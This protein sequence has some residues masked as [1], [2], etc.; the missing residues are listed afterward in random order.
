MEYLDVTDELGQPTGETVERSRAHREGIRHRT[1]HVWLLRRKDSRVQILLQKRSACKASYPGCFDI[2]SA[3]HIPAGCGWE[4][5]AL[6]ELREELGVILPAEA[7]IP[8]GVRTVCADT[9]FR[10]V[11]FHDR[12]VSRVYAA[13]TQLEEADFTLQ[14]EEVESV[15]WMDFDACEDAVLQNT[16]PHCIFPGELTILRSALGIPRK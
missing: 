13:W 4:E 11:P 14:Q 10:G 12:Q 5:S 15:L 7:L 2:S 8:A 1:A 6:R 9:V 3:G 16:I